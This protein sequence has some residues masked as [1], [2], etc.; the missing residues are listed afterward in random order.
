MTFKDIF[1]KSFIEGYSVSELDLPNIASC[2]L[3]ACLI[4]IF[5]FAIYRIICRKAFFNKNFSISLIALSVITAAVILTVQSSVVISLG[6]VGALSIVRFRTAIK[7]PLDLIFLF[8]SISCGIIAGAGLA[9]IAVALS[10]IIALILIIFN[11]IPAGKG[12]KLLLVSTTDTDS[13]KALVEAAKK[14]CRRVTV[15]SRSV[16]ADQLD[17][18]MEIT[19]A[20]EAVLT[21][22]MMN[23]SGVISS[24]LIAHDGEVTF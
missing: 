20:D 23:I 4:G 15:R 14:L 5:I 12:Q 17:L 10:I 21:R 19:G 11:V 9:V 13:E 2:L 7:D 3:V 24:S 1:K 22:E 18:I 16:T 8:W 6:M